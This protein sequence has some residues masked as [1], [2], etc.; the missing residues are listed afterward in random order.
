MYLYFISDLLALNFLTVQTFL[1]SLIKI[2]PGLCESVALD[3]RD[4]SRPQVTICISDHR[5]LIL[6][7]Y[8]VKNNSKFLSNCLVDI[9]AVDWLG[10][11][12]Q[13]CISFLN[14]N[15]CRFQLVYNLLSLYH[16]FRLRLLFFID[17]WLSV[18]SVTFMFRAAA[19][20][21]REVWDMFGVF[22]NKHSDLRRI[23]TDYGFNGFPLRKDFPLS[24]YEETSYSEVLKGVFYDVIELSQEMRNSNLINP[25][26]TSNSVLAKFYLPHSIKL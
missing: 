17:Q 20:F 24:G 3:Y 12:F 14:R 5:E 25:W 19:W 4:L 23:L 8:F 22:F 16:N 21:E 9:T 26:I 15:N 6:L 7:L 11:D 13:E 2:F 1:N 18:P 10:S